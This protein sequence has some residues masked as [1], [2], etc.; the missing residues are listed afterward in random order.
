MRLCKDKAIQQELAEHEL[1][2]KTM[3][4]EELKNYQVEIERKALEY[5]EFM[6]ATEESLI[7]EQIKILT[8]KSNK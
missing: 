7:N 6:M 4:A 5:E 2:K 8:N 3:T 1:R